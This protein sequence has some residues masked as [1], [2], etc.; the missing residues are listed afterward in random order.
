MSSDSDRGDSKSKSPEAWSSMPIDVDD[1]PGGTVGGQ[2]GSLTR[3][4][5]DSTFKHYL[6]KV[7]V[8]G[9]MMHLY[10]RYDST[11]LTMLG[12]QYFNQGSKVLVTL[13]A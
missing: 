1:E 13:A 2:R 7:P 4:E 12:M 11:F 3:L 6:R 10:G 8:L 9:F 5:G